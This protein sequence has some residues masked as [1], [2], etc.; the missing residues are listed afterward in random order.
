[1]TRRA[2][3]TFTGTLRPN[4]PRRFLV[5]AM[6]GAMG[7]DGKIHEAELA[8]MQRH[9]EEHEMFSGLSDRNHAVLLQIARD[10]I[11][12]AKDPVARI[13]AIAKGLPSRLHKLTALAMACE[14]VVADAVIDPAEELYLETLRGALRIA[15]PDFAEMFRAAREQ[16]SV[17]DLDARVAHLREL[18]PLIVELFA[19][20][21]LSLGV[22]TPAH[23]GQI[24]ELLTALPD[25]ALR[26]HELATLVERAYAR[27]HFSMDLEVEL[28]KVATAMPNPIDRYWAIIYLMCADTQRAPHWRSSP[29]LPLLQR[30]FALREEYFDLAATDAAGFASILP[31]AS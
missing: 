24:L 17:R 9:L 8:S 7:A 31:Q 27:M 23:R 13:P 22:L 1:M 4:D 6:L 19:L 11:S 28:Q 2:R 14:V 18:V 3:D 30:H 10:S 25:L 16:R 26:D 15:A 12:F 5:E 20:Q 21:S 29:F